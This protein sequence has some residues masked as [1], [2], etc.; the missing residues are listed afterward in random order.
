MSKHYDK[1]LASRVKREST[2]GLK[3]KVLNILD[4]DRVKEK[5]RNAI[6]DDHINN[7][8]LRRLRRSGLVFAG[9]SLGGTLALSGDAVAD[10]LVKHGHAESYRKKLEAAEEQREK[11][12][13]AQEILDRRDAE[14]EKYKRKLHDLGY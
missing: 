3:N 7:E 4:K 12:R 13:E 9:G 8:E 2:K 10:K 14:I 1:K 11:R 5:I 6:R